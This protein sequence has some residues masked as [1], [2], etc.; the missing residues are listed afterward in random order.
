MHDDTEQFRWGCEKHNGLMLV[1]PIFDD[2]DA[3]YDDYAKCM[4][5]LRDTQGIDLSTLAWRGVYNLEQFA[6][7]VMNR[8]IYFSTLTVQDDV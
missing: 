4:K 3:C 6:L 2:F 1:S 8:S 5:E 7:I